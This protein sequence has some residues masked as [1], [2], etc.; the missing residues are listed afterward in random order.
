MRPLQL[1]PLIV[2]LLVGACASDPA[3]VRTVPGCMV[4][5]LAIEFAGS[6]A[7][8]CGILSTYSNRAARNGVVSCARQA[9]A[10]GEAFRFGYGTIGDDAGY[11]NVAVRKGDGTLWSVNYEY[12]L[13]YSADD[14]RRGPSLQVAKC[15]SVSI[16]RQDGIKAHFFGLS[17][18]SEDQEAWQSV[19]QSIGRL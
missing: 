18:C 7:L 12:D 1:A 13:S 10:S 14:S 8:D 16:Q 6:G 17:G 11:C 15:T 2:L 9:I 3:V 4:P 19:A 5:S